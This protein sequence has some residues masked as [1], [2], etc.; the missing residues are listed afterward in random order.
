MDQIKSSTVIHVNTKKIP[1]GNR[2][3]GDNFTVNFGAGIQCCKGEKL[4]VNVQDFCM[5]KVWT[6][7]NDTNNKF[8]L[9]VKIS[10]N[11]NNYPLYLPNKNYYTVYD[12]AVAFG[13][14]IGD[15]LLVKVKTATP[16]VESWRF[17][18]TGPGGIPSGYVPFSPPSTA[19]INGTSSN[20]IEFQIEFLDAS[21]TVINLTDIIITGDGDDTSIK[22]KESE[23]DCAYLLGGDN[24]IDNDPSTFTSIVVEAANNSLPETV[25]FARVPGDAVIIRC[26]Y[27]AQRSTTPQI[28]LRSNL[29]STSLETHSFNQDVVTA[30]SNRLTHSDILCIIPVNTEFCKYFSEEGVRTI[31]AQDNITTLRLFITDEQGRQ[32]GRARGSSRDTAESN[33]NLSESITNSQSTRGNLNFTVTI[34]ID[35]IRDPNVQNKCV[36]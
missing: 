24:E 25:P 10:G 2:N 28:Y 3:T 36:R 8:N 1:P 17:Q 33:P 5:G 6:D 26:K 31:I 14:A 34:R 19:G 27:P 4:S 30:G 20:I 16:L 12:L 11:F 22:M 23:G 9:G 29:Y 35:V 13:T 18:I 15:K 32:I 7:V 21:N